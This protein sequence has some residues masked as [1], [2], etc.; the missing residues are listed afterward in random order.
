MLRPAV[1]TP[2]LI[3]QWPARIVHFQ[4]LCMIVKLSYCNR[5]HKNGINLISSLKEIY[6]KVSINTSKF[7]SCWPNT[8]GMVDNSKIGKQETMA[9]RLG[10]TDFSLLLNKIWQRNNNN[11]NNN[12]ISSLNTKFWYKRTS[13]SHVKHRL[14][15]I[16][17]KSCSA[18]GRSNLVPKELQ[19]KTIK[20]NKQT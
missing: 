19:N 3:V 14:I 13:P 18:Q 8:C 7:Q 20:T 12:N 6:V 4:L 5:P 16:L 10:W 1:C 15:T 17:I 9:V 11:N 2:S